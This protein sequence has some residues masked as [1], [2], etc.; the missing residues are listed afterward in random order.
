MD[1]EDPAGGEDG[2]QRDARPKGHG[3]SDC[4]RGS[5]HAIGQ[6]PA[7][8]R[9]MDDRVLFVVPVR[10]RTCSLRESECLRPP[11]RPARE[12]SKTQR[13]PSLLSVCVAGKEYVGI[14]RLH[15]AIESEHALSR[16]SLTASCWSKL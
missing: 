9:Y 12:H 13:P 16:V 10:L 5:S 6:V 1:Q 4:L 8:R 15:N 11:G 3:L 2:S 7:E 14:V